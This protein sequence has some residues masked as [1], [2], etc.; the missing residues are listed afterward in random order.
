[1]SSS[2][3]STVTSTDALD[4]TDAA[5]A[6]GPTRPGVTAALPLASG[7]ESLAVLWPLLRDRRGYLL[8]VAVAGLVGAVAGLVAPW[9]IGEMPWRTPS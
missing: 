7:R 6:G 5:Q 8:L 9:V 2:E 3:S 1:M 4:T